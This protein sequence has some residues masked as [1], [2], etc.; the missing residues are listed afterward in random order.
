MALESLLKVVRRGGSQDT[1]NAS[2][3]GNEQND[4]FIAQGA[5]PYTDL[6]RRGRG[7]SVVTAT[8]FAPQVVLP[9][10]IAKLEVKNGHATQLMVIDRVW[11]W[12]LLGTAAAQA[13]AVFAQVGAAV[14]S[15]ITGLVVYSANGSSKYT[16]VAGSPAEVAIDQTVVANGWQPFGAVQAWGTAAATPGPANVGE[17]EGRLVV[18]PGMAVHVTVTGSLATAS[19]FHCGVSW[20]FLGLTNEN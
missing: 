10:T 3:H 18:E 11:A 6:A 1:Q 14:Q 8:P 7:W 15:A 2:V 12:Q 19:S 4:L 5:P 16:S 13:Y 9:A 20:Y 17:V